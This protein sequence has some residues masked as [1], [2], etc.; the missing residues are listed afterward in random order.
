MTHLTAGLLISFFFLKILYDEE[1]RVIGIFNNTQDLI[2][3]YMAR[4]VEVHNIAPG[5]YHV[6]FKTGSV[7]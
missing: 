1:G 7:N 4:V 2:T 5:E 3:K 6:R